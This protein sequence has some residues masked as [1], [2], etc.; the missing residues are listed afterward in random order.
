M[1]EKTDPITAADL[2]RKDYVAVDKNSTVEKAIEEFK[3]FENETQKPSIYY[4]YVLDKNELVGTVSVKDLLNS[5]KDKQLKDLTTEEYVAFHPEEDIEKVA[6]LSA[7]YD[8]QAFPVV[9]KD[10]LIG[11]VRLDEILEILEKEETE[12]IYKKAGFTVDEVS[13]SDHLLNSSILS[14]IGIRLPWLLVA[15]IG[16]FLAAQVIEVFERQ[17]LEVAVLAFFIPLI[18]DMG[19][20]VGTQSSTIFVRGRVLD[21]IKDSEMIKYL[22]KESLIGGLIGFIT[23]GLAAIAALLLYGNIQ[24]SYVLVISMTFTCIVASFI[25]FA[26]PFTAQKLGY[27]PAAVSDPI[28]TTIKDISALLIYFG[29]A[30]IILGL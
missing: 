15:L 22:F 11:I 7:K 10:S 18:M 13:K 6:R 26:V 25:G 2:S 4:I 8:Y 27:D 28:I 21:Q 3:K 23:G 9:E 14:V 16:G 1:K 17:L 24:V 5:K 19:G 29:S 20:N 30:A 12:D